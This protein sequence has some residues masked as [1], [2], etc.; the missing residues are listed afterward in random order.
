M[1]AQ[2]ADVYTQGV[3]MADEG[4]EACFGQEAWPEQGAPLAQG[5][6]LEGSDQKTCPAGGGGSAAC[7]GFLRG[8]QALPCEQSLLQECSVRK[9]GCSP[10]EWRSS[11]AHTIMMMAEVSIELH[12]VTADS[13]RINCCD[14]CVICFTVT[15]AL[16][17]K[18]M[19]FISPAL[20]SGS[21]V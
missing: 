11:A 17:S 9:Y 12:L 15:H 5:R 3:A 21:D 16:L 13:S 6:P 14:A 19:H 2:A 7:E 18:R 20:V 4:V 8:L 1:L 10:M